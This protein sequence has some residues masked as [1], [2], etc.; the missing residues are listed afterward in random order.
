MLVGQTKI[1]AGKAVI[2]GHEFTRNQEMVSIILLFKKNI[3]ILKIKFNLSSHIRNVQEISIKVF[4]EK[5]V[6]FVSSIS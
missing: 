1:S 5:Y 3:Y 6:A 2:H 4:N